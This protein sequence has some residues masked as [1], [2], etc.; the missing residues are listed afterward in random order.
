MQAL[1]KETVPLSTVLESCRKHWR[2]GAFF[3]HEPWGRSPAHTWSW[4]SCHPLAQLSGEQVEHKYLRAGCPAV[5][6]KAAHQVQLVIPET[7]SVANTLQCPLS[8]GEAEPPR[9]SLTCREGWGC[10]LAVD[11][12]LSSRTPF[13]MPPRP[14]K[15]HGCPGHRG[16]C[17]QRLV[18]CLASVP[19]TPLRRAPLRSMRHV[20]VPMAPCGTPARCCSLAWPAALS[21]ERPQG[22]PVRGQETGEWQN[23]PQ[24]WTPSLA[25]SPRAYL[26]LIPAP[27][28]R[29]F[30]LL[31]V[32]APQEK[33]LVATAW[34]VGGQQ[35][36]TV[37]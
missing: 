22:S 27:V 19:R 36:G 25:L 12:F 29:H 31:G 8:T 30:T 23:S 6:A 24:S 26:N 16:H 21:N 11:S 35:S 37:A 2:D 9:R 14:P 32:A 3:A 10:R 33:E 5:W 28:P 20:G 1:P 7:G 34:S 4:T 15:S 13:P 17:T 18:P